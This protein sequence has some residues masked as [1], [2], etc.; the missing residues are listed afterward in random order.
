MVRLREIQA[1]ADKRK[2]EHFN[3]NMVRLRVRWPRRR[4]LW[5]WRIS[6]PTWYD[7]ELSWM[8]DGWESVHFNSNMVR[9][10]D[11]IEKHGRLPELAFQFQ[12]GTIERLQSALNALTAQDFNSNMVRLRGVVHKESWSKLCWISIPTWYDWEICQGFQKNNLIQY[13]N[14]NMVR[15]RVYTNDN[16]IELVDLFQFQHGTI[17]RQKG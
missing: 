16:Y 5:V 7:W 1:E 11:Y 14:S 6:I 10:R 12:H 4:Y 15:L 17:E 13:F 8:S 3:S 2:K 9:L